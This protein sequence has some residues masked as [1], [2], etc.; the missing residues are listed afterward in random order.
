MSKITLHLDTASITKSENFYLL[1]V[2]FP[3]CVLVIWYGISFRLAYC[4]PLNNKKLYAV[5]IST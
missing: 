4:V 3:S 5:F 2:K 1:K